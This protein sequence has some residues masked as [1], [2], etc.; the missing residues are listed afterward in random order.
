MRKIMK[1]RYFLAFLFTAICLTASASCGTTDY[2]GSTGRLYDMVTYVLTMCS[3]VAQLTYVIATLLSFYCAI[4]IYIKL[5]TGEDGFAKSVLILIGSLIFLASA[6]FVFPAF[7]G[8][9]YG[10]TD[11]LW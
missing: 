9:R 1:K 5:Q 2:S 4:N 7:F 3:Y 11:H 6:T 10:V 8:F